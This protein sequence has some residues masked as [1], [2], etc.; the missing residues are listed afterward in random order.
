MEVQIVRNRLQTEK[1]VG[2][3]Y[4]RLDNVRDE[5]GADMSKELREAMEVEQY[6]NM[7]YVD[8]QIDIYAPFKDENMY[9]DYDPIDMNGIYY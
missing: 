2:S 8:S 7:D 9:L 3:R 5:K 6:E 1:R 4:Y